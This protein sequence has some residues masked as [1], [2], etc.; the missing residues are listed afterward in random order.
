[1]AQD[2]PGPPGATTTMT[3][4]AYDPPNRWPSCPTSSDVPGSTT[5]APTAPWVRLSTL[6]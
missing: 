4:P 1:M 3:D 6:A 5:A 2:Q